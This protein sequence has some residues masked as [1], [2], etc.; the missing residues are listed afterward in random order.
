MRSIAI[1]ISVPF[2]VI[3]TPVAITVVPMSMMV[4]SPFTVTLCVILAFS[5][6]FEQHPPLHWIVHHSVISGLLLLLDSQHRIFSYLGRGISGS[7]CSLNSH[8]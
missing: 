4:L 7:V 1:A 3:S 5:D 6:S 8:E 2:V